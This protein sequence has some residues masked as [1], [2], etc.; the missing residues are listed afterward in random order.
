MNCGTQH[1]RNR[2]S[3]FMKNEIYILTLFLLLASCKNNE[4]ETEWQKI[5]ESNSIETFQAYLIANPY[6]NHLTEIIDSLRVLWKIETFKNWHRDCFGNCLSLTINK[7]GQLIFEGKTIEKKKL[8]EIIKYSILNPENLE[9]LP[10]KKLIELEGLGDFYVSN[11]FIDIVSEQGLT[12]KKHSEIIKLVKDSFIE[13]RN[14]YSTNLFDKVFNKLNQQQK[15][16]IET[17]VP[18]RIRFER[19]SFGPP[20]IPPPPPDSVELVIRKVG[21]NES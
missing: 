5:K 1:N 4:S 16:T 8:K 19:Y 12:P 20:E 10:E 7:N 21:L 2:C 18:I 14:E 13:L 3:T 9:F 17:L 15:N 6:S 11:G